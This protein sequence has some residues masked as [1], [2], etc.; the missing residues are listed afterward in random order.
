MTYLHADEILDVRTHQEV[1]MPPALGSPCR[2]ELGDHAPQTNAA[3]GGARPPNML[4]AQLFDEIVALG[5]LLGV[6]V[7]LVEAVDVGQ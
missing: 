1:A 4:L 5:P 6:R 2:L 7:G 3:G